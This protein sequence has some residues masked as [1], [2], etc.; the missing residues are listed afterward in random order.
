M[1]FECQNLVWKYEVWPNEA[2]QSNTKCQLLVN[3]M[4]QA[5]YE[6]MMV[7][8]IEVLQYHKELELKWYAHLLIEAETP[9]WW[10]QNNLCSKGLKMK[11]RVLL[12]GSGAES[13]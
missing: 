6:E 11:A 5:I 2:A 9:L 10:D 1:S 12:W 13:E 7:S 4:N 3:G 8:V